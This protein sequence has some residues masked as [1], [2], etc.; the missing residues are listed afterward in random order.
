MQKILI[1]LLLIM[2]SHSSAQSIQKNFQITRQS[3]VNYLL[4]L[5][6]AYDSA[7]TATF[8]L[9]LFLHGRGESGSDLH[10]VSFP[11]KTIESREVSLPPYLDSER[12][13]DRKRM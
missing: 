11:Y 4:Y 12:L 2:T 1:I 7:P 10:L 9:I 8:P 5:P 3:D 6:S 13:I